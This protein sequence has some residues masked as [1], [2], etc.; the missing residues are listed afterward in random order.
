MPALNRIAY[1]QSRRDEALNVELAKELAAKK[2]K[3]GIGEI[4]AELSNKNANIANDCIKVLYEVGAIDPSLIADYASDFLKLLQS[5]NNRMA[6]GAM[7]ALAA[8]AELK[9]DVIYKQLSA[10]QEAMT[11]GSVITMD[12][13]VKVLALVAASSKARSAKVFPFLL[14]HLA[15]CRPKDVPQHSEKS[16]VAVTAGNQEAFVAVLNKR[17]PKLTA[18]QATRVKKVIKAAEA[19]A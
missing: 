14:T 1:F 13:G 4:A 19:K 9:A 17:L 12:N 11:N 6:W 8:I 7:T 5:K 10:V 3:A 18:S 16:L 15:T 2:D